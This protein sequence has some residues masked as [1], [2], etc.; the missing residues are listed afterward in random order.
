[1]VQESIK[2]LLLNYSEEYETEAFIIGDPSW[3]MHHVSGNNNREAMAFVASGIS[4]GSRQQFMKKINML[5][6]W[7][8]GDADTWIKDGLYLNWF[9]E[10]DNRCF[11]RLQTYDDM[12]H[13]ISSYQ[14]LLR[15]Y[16][17]LGEYVKQNAEDG[18][19]AIQSIVSFFYI[20]GSGGII[21]KTTTSAC[22][23]LCMFLR[24]MCRTNSPVDIGLWSDFIDRRSLIIPMDTHVL[25]QA[26]RL[27]LIKS[28]TASM[29]SAIKLTNTLKEV[30]PND[31]LKGDF[32]LFGYGVNNK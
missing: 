9:S 18:L 15:T 1:M 26:N 10:G 11:Y 29:T 22:K 17:S 13:F 8:R 3:F 21:P 16:G 25:Q 12:F 2:K 32:A 31:P 27:E 19:S 28:S 6:E 4:Y 20:H 23:R 24:W 5:L 14:Y 7:S 30:F